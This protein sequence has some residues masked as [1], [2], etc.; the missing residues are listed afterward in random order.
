MKMR[1]KSFQWN[2]WIHVKTENLNRDVSLTPRTKIAQ[3]LRALRCSQL[4]YMSCSFE[5]CS[6]WLNNLAC[7]LM[8]NLIFYTE[9]FYII[10]QNRYKM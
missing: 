3:D 7:I 6:R 8:V 9:R 2:F 5:S 1:E 4:L 10:N